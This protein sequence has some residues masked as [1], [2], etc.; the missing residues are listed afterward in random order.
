MNSNSLKWQGK[1][2]VASTISQAFWD[3]PNSKVKEEEAALLFWVQ[4][5]SA[6]SRHSKTHQQFEY[7]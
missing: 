5:L 3:H 4:E 1:E 7:F 2:I 6:K